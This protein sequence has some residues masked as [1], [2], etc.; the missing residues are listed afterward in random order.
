VVGLVIVL[1]GSGPG[2]AGGVSTFRDEFRS[3]QPVPVTG[4]P[5]VAASAPTH[6]GTPPAWSTPRGSF[7]VSG[8]ALIGGPT[9]SADTPSLAVVEA[10]RP[11]HTIEARFDRVNGDLGVIFR[12]ADPHNY[13]ILVPAPS[14]ATWNLY[15]VESGNTLFR[16]N[17]GFSGLGR[18]TATLKL[19]GTDIEVDVGRGPRAK[20]S[21]DV[22][23]GSRGAGLIAF[24]GAS[25][26]RDSEPGRC[27]EFAMTV[28]R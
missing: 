17:T 9:S 10:S 5:L 6:P 25:P 28:E 19:S 4:R 14:Y 2:S 12:Y 24:S 18:G 3:S 20:L 27:V 22:L 15:S 23:A 16:G 7:V 1:L 8:A 26:G 11:V 13:W 21:S